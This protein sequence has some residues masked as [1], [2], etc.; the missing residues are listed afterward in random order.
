M[1]KREC[2]RCDASVT[3]ND[4]T[5][6]LPP[7]GWKRIEIGGDSLEL[8]QGCVDEWKRRLD[9]LG[10]DFLRPVPVERPLPSVSVE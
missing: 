2:D 3:T 5:V 9:D 8:C 4:D 1:L 6:P 7:S 10:K